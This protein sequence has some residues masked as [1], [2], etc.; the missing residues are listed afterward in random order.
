MAKTFTDD[1]DALLAELGI[2]VD[3]KP[4]SSRGPREERIIAGFE[5]IPLEAWP[6]QPEL[7]HMLRE[8]FNANAGDWQKQMELVVKDRPP[9]TLLIHGSRLPES[10]LLDMLSTQGYGACG[11][12]ISAMGQSANE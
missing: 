7:G 9:R 5:D 1:D 12:P 11:Q 3:A 4:T 8:G 2:A 10:R 6:R